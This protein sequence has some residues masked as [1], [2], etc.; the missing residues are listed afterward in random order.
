MLS[1]S[2]SPERLLVGDLLPWQCSFGQFSYQF[3]SV[4]NLKVLPIHKGDK[5]PAGQQPRSITVTAAVTVM[6]LDGGSKTAAV[7]L[8]CHHE[9]LRDSMQCAHLLFLC[10]G[11]VGGGVQSHAGVVLGSH[12]GQ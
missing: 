11:R 1:G 9:A 6:L 8:C 4:E 3:L 2:P 10:V 7:L 12:R 5:G